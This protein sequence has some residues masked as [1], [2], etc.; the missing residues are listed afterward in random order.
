MGIDFTYRVEVD[1]SKIHTMG[2]PWPF[3]GREE[4][5]S[6]HCDC[7]TRDVCSSYDC[8]WHERVDFPIDGPGGEVINRVDLKSLSGRELLGFQVR[9]LQ[10]TLRRPLL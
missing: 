4:E 3:I 2:Q 5:G 8:M 7:R 9:L 10:A 6:V 1:G